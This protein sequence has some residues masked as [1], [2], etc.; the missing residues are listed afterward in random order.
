MVAL[1][2]EKRVL[3]FDILKSICAFLI[4]CIH[5]PFPG[6]VGSYITALSR[7]AVPIFFM[8]TGYFYSEVTRKRKITRQIMK[9]FILMIEANLLYLVWKWFCTVVSS[10]VNFLSNTF[11]VKNLLRFIFFN[12]SSLSGHLWYLGAILYV[13]IITAIADKLKL[14]KALYWLTPLLLVMDLILGKYSLILLKREFPYILVRNFLFVGVPYFCIGRMIREGLGQKIKKNTAAFLIVLFSL[15]TC[16][17]RFI[18][19]SIDMNPTRDHY[20]SSTLL[21]VAV[22]LFMLKLRGD[23]TTE[24]SCETGCELRCVEKQ[25]TPHKVMTCV[26][27]GGIQAC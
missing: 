3:I 11:N 13:L 21:A 27:G 23:Q 8:I 25:L 2:N 20:L 17:E 16:V 15:T 4:V 24:R 26:R 18:L 12:D 10:D 6:E 9:I 5:V 14:S 7:I 19:V 22:F 1:H